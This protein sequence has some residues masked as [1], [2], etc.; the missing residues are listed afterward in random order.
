MGKLSAVGLPAGNYLAA[1]VPDEVPDRRAHPDY[2][3]D[4]LRPV[5]TSF[6]ITDGA[7]TAITLRVRR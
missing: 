5:A 7:T 4:S 2:L 3:F 1:L 6:P